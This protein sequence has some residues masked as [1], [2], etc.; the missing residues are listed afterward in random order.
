MAAQGGSGMQR[1]IDD[2]G[3]TVGRCATSWP[4]GARLEVRFFRSVN[5]D[6]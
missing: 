1:G 6:F 5:P 3:Y 2:R 4:G